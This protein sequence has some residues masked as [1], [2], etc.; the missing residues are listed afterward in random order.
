M[1]TTISEFIFSQPGSAESYYANDSVTV[2]KEQPS[3]SFVRD[4]LA[5]QSVKYKKDIEAYLEIS[6][7]VRYYLL[8]S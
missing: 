1:E 2:W 8:L 3:W 4:P 5:V 7:R 6:Y